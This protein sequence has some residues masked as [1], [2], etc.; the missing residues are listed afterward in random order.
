MYTGGDKGRV[1]PQDQRGGGGGGTKR[2][3]STKKDHE[4]TRDVQIRWRGWG[5]TRHPVC[6][7]FVSSV[8]SFGES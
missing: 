4:G 1:G 8:L 2:P 3:E 5:N 7:T 6:S